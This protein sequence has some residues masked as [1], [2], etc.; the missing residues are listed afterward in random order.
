MKNLFTIVLFIFFISAHL[1]AEEMPGYEGNYNSQPDG[2]E[3]RKIYTA[4]IYEQILK[5]NLYFN[6]DTESE[7]I[8]LRTESS[9]SS[10]LIFNGQRIQ[11][12][13]H[14]WISYNGKTCIAVTDKNE[15]YIIGNNSKFGPYRN[16]EEPN[17]SSDERFWITAV[18][19]K[20]G[21]WRILTSNGDEYGAFREKVFP[22]IS[23][24]GRHW[25]A[26]VKK[27]DGKSYLFTGG[28][29][30]FGPFYRAEA[31]A[32]SSDGKFWITA[33]QKEDGK[34]YIRSSDGKEFGPFLNIEYPSFI[35]GDKSWIAAVQPYNG[36]KYFLT[37][38][39]KKMGAFVWA[40]KPVFRSGKNQ[41]FARIKKADLKEYILF[42]DGREEGPFL[43]DV[44]PDTVAYNTKWITRSEDYDYK[45]KK[46]L[47]NLH[48]NNGKTMGPYESIQKKFPYDTTKHWGVVVR[49]DDPDDY[50]E[51]LILNDGR[52][53][54]P[55]DEVHQL[56]F[57]PNGKVWIAWI[58]KL[59]GEYVLIN[60]DGKEKK[61]T[62]EVEWIYFSPNGKQWFARIETPGR[63]K[64][65][66][67]RD[68][69]L[70][71]LTGDKAP[72]IFFSPDGNNWIMGP[73]KSH[74]GQDK[75]Y[76]VTGD[77]KEIESSAPIE[78]ATFSPDGKKWVITSGNNLIFSDGRKYKYSWLPQMIHST[79][80]PYFYWFTAI[81][82]DLFLYRLPWARVG[83]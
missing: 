20:D 8:Y 16:A 26:A 2:V 83:N 64:K 39:G 1:H 45:R 68:G 67:F 17:F 52:I 65:L 73:V 53:L 72:N 57:S 38:D 33:I 79:G 22:S 18:Q 34:R 46:Y 77:G 12:S 48:F 56:V 70:Y 30:E 71:P 9:K 63:Y 44:N 55:Y 13:N 3:R 10:W 7:G 51:Y 59:N 61:Q 36:T 28:E 31:P 42:S 54:G 66:Q 35:P 80:I 11:D 23:S 5:R 49:K 62:G 14:F 78:T 74:E 60:S 21:K 81:D 47:W 41:W 76:I 4:I 19:K 6:T 24:G 43:H 58:E 82:S 37:S 69:R 15:H 50:S 32:I 27:D 40:N 75:L 29:K 25:I